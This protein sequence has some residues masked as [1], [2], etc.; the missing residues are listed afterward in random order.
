MEAGKHGTAL[1]LGS[2]PGFQSIA[3]A[4]L[5]FEKVVAVDTS[6]TLLD[7]LNNQKGDLP[8]ET[9]LADL[10][11]FDR[12]AVPGSSEAI[13]CMGDTLTHLDSMQDVKDVFRKA[14]DVLQPSGLLILTFRDLS[15]ELTGLDR[16]SPFAL[17]AIAS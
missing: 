12:L 5:G 10:R 7:E 13:V 8:I 6:Q 17:I 15:I 14:R 16:I 1:D 4:S 11:G 3:L 9:A 2:G